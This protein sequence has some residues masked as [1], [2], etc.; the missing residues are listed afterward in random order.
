M[1]RK[2]KKSSSGTLGFRQL[3]ALLLVGTV[4][5]ALKVIF[6]DYTLDEEYQVV[7]A[8]R[9]LA[10]DYLFDAMWEPHQTSAFACVWLM[11]LFLAVTGSTTGVVLFLRVCTTI[12][13]IV[14]ARWLY[15]VCCHYTR[16]EYAFLLGLGY[17]NIIPKIIQIPEFSNLQVWFFTV[18]VLSLMQYYEKDKDTVKVSKIK[19]KLWLIL[20][21]TGM[22]FEVLSYPS[23]LI[24]FPFF[25]ICIFVQSKGKKDVSGASGGSR[26]ALKDCLIFSGVCGIDALVWLGYVL[27]HVSLSTFLRN[28]GYVLAFDLT[29]DISLT[30]KLTLVS[31]T[32][33]IRSFLLPLSV[34]VF[35]GLLV[36]I[37]LYFV[38]MRKRQEGLKRSV[39]AVLLVLVAEIVQVFYWVVL[40]S[41]YET[42]LIHLLV[43]M[44]A[45]T[46]VWRLADSRKKVFCIGLIGSVI[47]IVT[48]IYMSDLS[49]WYAIPHGMLGSLFAALILIYALESEL[50]ERSSSWTQILLV[51]LVVVSIFGKGFTLRNGTTE[52]N[53]VL[54]IRGVVSEGPTTGIF[55]NYMQAYIT[56]STYEEFEQ[57]VEEGANCLIVTNM[58]GTAGT[59][60]YLF[61]NSNVC[62]FSVIDPTSYDEKLL[63]YWSLY[64]DKR[65]DVI[66]VDCWYGQLIENE[67]SWIMQYIESDFNYSRTEDGKYL[68]YYFR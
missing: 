46:L 15:R 56:N 28:V 52:T 32:G 55:M 16:R 11:R 27:Q 20:A 24:L 66:V 23:C 43:L 60:P 64:P 49:A 18:I 61:R 50:G 8:Y 3:K 2:K 65:P 12:I 5:A 59:S 30:A 53:S 25:L 10:G 26:R 41:G 17:F 57:F 62:H 33:N 48:V 44:L 63:T 47:T 58:V 9:R 40:K 4:L 68:R 1:G 36:W 42:P 13:Q 39:L 6:V 38:R 19:Q 54:G 34:T 31:L 45:A 51:S 14:L 29:H 22:A 37:V 67:D 21:G 7:M 35:F